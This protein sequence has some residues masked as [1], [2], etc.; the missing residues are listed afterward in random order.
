[1]INAN[2]IHFNL[3]GFDVNLYQEYLRARV[4]RPRMTHKLSYWEQ[5][6][7]HITKWEYHQ[8]VTNDELL[9]KTIFYGQK[10]QLVPHNQIFRP[11]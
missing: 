7:G 2:L 10:G 9:S 5:E 8:I 6:N 1:M 3:D 11:N 4:L